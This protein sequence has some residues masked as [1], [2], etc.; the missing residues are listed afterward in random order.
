MFQSLEIQNS[1]VK[2]ERNQYMAPYPRAEMSP[3]AVA[4]D[5]AQFVTLLFDR[6]N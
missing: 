5:N 3:P 4:T 1:I 2:L 6:L